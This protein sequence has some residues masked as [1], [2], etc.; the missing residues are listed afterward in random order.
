MSGEYWRRIQDSTRNLARKQDE[1]ARVRAVKEQ[2]RRDAM[3]AK[4][5]ASAERGR[6]YSEQR[7]RIEAAILTPVLELIFPAYR[8]IATN[9]TKVRSSALRPW[10][11]HTEEQHATLIFLRWGRKYEITAEEK[12][13]VAKSYSPAADGG[14][15]LLSRIAGSRLPNEIVA[16]D[17]EQIA[18]ELSIEIR[19]D[20]DTPHVDEG[21]TFVQLPYGTNV[22]LDFISYDNRR[23]F[24]DFLSDHSWLFNMLAAQL[25]KPLHIHNIHRKGSRYWSNKHP[26]HEHEYRS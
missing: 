18:M 2:E 1:A 24:R 19:R 15:K 12:A 26:Y 9:S 16:C 13:V 20:G 4:Q 6:R 7:D 23:D 25:E 14:S 22:S 10:I 17:Y 8:D 21:K 5:D 11:G 3:K